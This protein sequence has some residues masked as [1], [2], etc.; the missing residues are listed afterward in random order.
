MFGSGNKDK[1]SKAKGN[2]P[3]VNPNAINTFVVG[4]EFEG[5]LTSENDIRIDGVMKGTLS[6]SGRLI[7]GQPGFLEGEVEC[8]NAVIE[9]E[10]KGNLKVEET[11]QVKEKA[12]IEGE[13]KTGK[14][15]VQAGAIFNVNCQMGE[16]RLGG[17]DVSAK[18]K[19]KEDKGKLAGGEK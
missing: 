3:P 8:R 2:K 5:K 15:I 1:G 14:L 11:L 17:K 16:Q 6:C 18:P 12:V 13:I 9:G 4:T 19:E 7:I 10:F